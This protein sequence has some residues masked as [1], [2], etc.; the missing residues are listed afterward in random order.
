M[1]NRKVRNAII[2]ILIAGPLLLCS[3]GIYFITRKVDYFQESSSLEA[4]L[5]K[6]KAAGF[7]MTR[8]EVEPEVVS[9][10]ENAMPLYTSLIKNW[11]KSAPPKKIDDL[12]KV[13]YKSNDRLP[14]FDSIIDQ[15]EK[16]PKLKLNKDWDLGAFATFPELLVAKR[17]TRVMALQA[18]AEARKG[19]SQFVDKRIRLML[20]VSDTF[21]NSPLM[22]PFLVGL[23]EHSITTLAAVDCVTVSQG[24]PRIVKVVTDVLNEPLSKVDY[25]GVLRGEF[26]VGVATMRNV[27][28]MKEAQGAT[29]EKPTWL[30][31]PTRSG[32]PRKLTLKANLSFYTKTALAVDTMLAMRKDDNQLP[33]ALRE[34]ESKIPET[35]SSVMTHILLPF[36]S[37]AVEADQM[38]K[39]RCTVALS[40]IAL[41]NRVLATKKIPRASVDAK[42]LPTDPYSGQPLKMKIRKG[43]VLVYSVGPNRKDEGGPQTRGKESDDFGFSFTIPKGAN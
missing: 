28:S 18:V 3:G 2:A 16:R 42:L 35:T 38:V 7:P 11:P 20:R 26:Y 9:E 21:R 29:D 12:Y 6:A 22:I 34:F 15:L 24:N 23:S 4:E 27:K 10:N 37:Q 41:Y 14:E 13:L 31:N 1:D 39:P 33:V 30:D 19:N 17:I 8:E 25:R 43:V 40:A 5:A 36:F 32:V